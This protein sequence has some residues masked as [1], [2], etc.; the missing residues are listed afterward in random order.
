MEIPWPFKA[1]Q[2]LC[3]HAI[4][5]KWPFVF[6]CILFRCWVLLEILGI[7]HNIITSMTQI[8]FNCSLF[9]TRF[10]NHVMLSFSIDQYVVSTPCKAQSSRSAVQ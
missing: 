9:I 5:T 4:Q 3:S 10:R 2:S 8:S 7:Q 1:T 6:F